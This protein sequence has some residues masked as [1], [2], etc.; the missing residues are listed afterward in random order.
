MVSWQ[1][2]QSLRAA[3]ASPRTF[4]FIDGTGASHHVEA[5]NATDAWVA[6]SFREEAEVEELIDRGWRIDFQR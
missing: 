1:D 2:P 5:S 6:L 4:I 3:S